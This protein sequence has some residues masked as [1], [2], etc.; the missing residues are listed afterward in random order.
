MLVSQYTEDIH[1]MAEQ[2]GLAKGHCD[3][4]QMVSM[5]VLCLMKN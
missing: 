4:L 5:Y 1:R 2:I 3:H